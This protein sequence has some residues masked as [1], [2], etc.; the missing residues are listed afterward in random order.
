MELWGAQGHV[1]RWYEVLKVWR[2]WA[3]DV[4]GEALDCGH[5]LA[6]EAPEATLQALRPFLRRIS[7]PTK[8]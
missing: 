1:H 2:D 6:E 4:Q 7:A 8:E 5:Y 3:D